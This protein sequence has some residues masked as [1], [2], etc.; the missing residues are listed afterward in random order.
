VDELINPITGG[1]D[2]QLVHDTFWPEDANEILRIPIDDRMEDWPAWHFD[3]KGLFSVKSAYKLAVARRDALAHM[4]AS[5]SGTVSNREGEFQWHK[6]WQLKVPNKIQMFIWHLAHNNLPVKRNLA[7][8]GIKK[9]T[10]C[11]VC[12]RLDKDCS[13]IFSN[14]NM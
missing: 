13:H 2:V 5:T 4:D 1:W 8:R 10:L 12:N 9:D 11:L 14:V 6:I 7:H 3:S